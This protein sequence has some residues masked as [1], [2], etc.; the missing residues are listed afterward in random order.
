M[1]PDGRNEPV[2]CSYCSVAEACLRGDSGSRLRLA[3]WTEDSSGIGTEEEALLRVWRLREPH[4]P[5]GRGERE[6]VNALRQADREARRAA[7]TRFDRPLVLQAGAGTGK[8]TTLIGRL[9]A[10]SLGQGWDL[11]VQRLAAKP[12]FGRREEATP[13]RIAAEVLGRVVAITFTEAAAAEMAG[14]AAREL[15]VLSAGGEAPSWLEASV[16]PPPAETTIRARALLG[17]LDHLSVRT[18]HAFC[19]GLLADHPLEAG[20]HPD[21]TIDADGTLVEAAVRETVEDSLRESYGEPGD[22][23]L[24]ALVA[25]GYG[26]QE[27]VEAL[28][29]LLRYGLPS[30]ALEIDP[31]GPEAV[32]AF[33]DRLHKACQDVHRLIAFRVRGS[34]AKN[35]QKIEEGLRVLLGRLEGGRLEGETEDLDSLR[36]AAVQALPENL[37]K[38]LHEWNRSRLNDTEAGLFGDVRAEL[39]A[40]SASL[41][42]ILQHFA[43]V[44]PGLLDHGRQALRPLLARV[45]EELRRNGIATFDFLLQGAESLLA[46]NA[47]VR[48][49]VRRRIDQLLVDEFQD[50][51]RTQCE[52]LRWIALDGA[53]ADRPGLFLVG[54]PKQSIYG[55][56]SADLAGVR[57][58]RG[59]RARGGRRGHVA[60]RKLPLGAGDAGRGRAGDR[61]GHAWSARAS[62]RR[63]SRCCRA[64]GGRRTPASG[65]GTEGAGWSP[66]EHWVSWSP[67]GDR[68]ERSAWRTLSVDA[69]RSRPPPWPRTRARSTRTTAWPGGRSPSCCAARATWTS[70]S[71][72]CGGRGSRSPWGATSSTTGAARS[73]RPRPWCAACSIPAI[74]WR[75]S[76]CSAR[77]WSA[78]PTR[79]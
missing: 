74:T 32:A 22:P 14:R 33:R 5:D 53:V 76:P 29:D 27:V 71:K 51:D 16:L 46:G 40:A 12:S 69:A 60:A 59:A 73:S 35:A 50:T 6:T 72:R 42:Q 57:R 3:A 45:E 54:D 25:Q 8:T 78:C 52:I 4:P 38:H 28:L 19:L 24:L 9:L 31:F 21:L 18:I 75:S 58:L 49:Q 2:R 17:T 68:G 1:E 55:W 56:R 44:D 10:W 65:G 48:R 7:Q 67:E 77:R 66:V 15:A 64:S 23:H 63:S 36:E 47:E 61:A 20:V 13:D 30:A 37:V 41:E 62:S 11:A 39:S 70:I 79:R 26:P 43:R 34:R